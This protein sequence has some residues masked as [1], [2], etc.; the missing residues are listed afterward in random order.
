MRRNCYLVGGAWAYGVCGDKSV[1]KPCNEYSQRGVNGTARDPL[2]K[3]GYL[4]ADQIGKIKTFGVAKA[5]NGRAVYRN[6]GAAFLSRALFSLSFFYEKLAYAKAP[7]LVFAEYGT[8]RI[9]A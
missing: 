6:V 2:C 9:R 3:V 8:R 5:E 4:F 1:S 7:A